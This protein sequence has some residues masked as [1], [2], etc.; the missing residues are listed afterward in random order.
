MSSRWFPDNEV[1]IE[2]SPSVIVLRDDVDEVRLPATVW[3][4]LDGTFEAVDD[5]SPES[6]GMRRIELFNP[7]PWDLDVARGELLRRLLRFGLTRFAEGVMFRVRP[8]VRFGSLESF[9]PILGGFQ[10][11]L[12][13]WAAI[14]AGA[15]EVRFD[16]QDVAHPR[17][18]SGEAPASATRTAATP[19]DPNRGSRST[20]AKGHHPGS[21]NVTYAMDY[22]RQTFVRLNRNLMPR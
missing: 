22:W 3:V 20:S 10:R 2:A 4:M 12:F 14:N 16:P 13:E 15:K 5:R 7:S 18:A 11:D 21:G 6:A 8:I 17:L 19:P 9:T 1:R